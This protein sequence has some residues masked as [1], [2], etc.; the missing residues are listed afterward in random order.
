MGFFN[1][2]IYPFGVLYADQA[3]INSVLLPSEPRSGMPGHKSEP[4]QHNFYIGGSKVTGVPYIWFIDHMYGSSESDEDYFDDDDYTG[5]WKV[6][7]EA[8]TE[9]WMM[10]IV[11]LRPIQQFWP[12]AGE[13]D[14]LSSLQ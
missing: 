3:A 12:G 6:A 5:H 14:I 1:S 4:P 7:L 8:V 10:T 13:N 2:N 9:F 11:M